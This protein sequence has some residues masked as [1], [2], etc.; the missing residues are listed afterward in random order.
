MK[1]GCNDPFLEAGLSLDEELPSAIKPSQTIVNGYKYSV[2]VSCT[3]NIQIGTVDN[4]QYIQCGR[5]FKKAPDDIE[6]F[7]SGTKLKQEV[8]L[9]DNLLMINYLEEDCPVDCIISKAG[10]CG[11][12]NM[13]DQT[14]FVFSSMAPWTIEAEIQKPLGWSYRVCVSCKNIGDYQ[15]IDNY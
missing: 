10:A 13:E 1:P 6:V 12:N 9:T 3:N 15:H 8:L 7:Y 2:C 4:V 11:Q 14:D 5:I